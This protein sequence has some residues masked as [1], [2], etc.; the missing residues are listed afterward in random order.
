MSR[1]KRICALI[2]AGGQGQRAGGG[3]PKQYR[4]VGG[5]PVLRWAI[6]A[7]G[8]AVPG[9]LIT[10][11]ALP[12]HRAL[13]DSAVQGLSLAPPIAGGASRAESVRNGLVALAVDEPDIVLIHDAAR[14]FVTPATVERLIAA[15]ADGEVQGAAPGLRASDSLKRVGAD[16]SIEADIDRSRLWS[17]QTPQVFRYESIALAFRTHFSADATDDVAIARA[18][19]LKVQMVDGDPANV[20]LTYA[21]DFA[22]A[23]KRITAALGDVRT[24]AGLDVHAFGS[25]DH[26]YLCGIKV[27]HA[28]GLVGHS[29]ADVGLHALTDAILGAIGAGDI[30]VHFP[31]SDERWRGASSD[32]F[33]RHAQSLVERKGG[34]IAHCDVTLICEAPKI[35][36][37]RTAMVARI[38]EILSIDPSRV[39]VKATTTEGLGFA[40]RREGI[41]AMATATVRLPL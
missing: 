4:P 23:E 13:Y 35:G 18:A 8:E 33:L 11:V 2:V 14:P 39:S 6:Q 30:G 28:F 36:L 32:H 20:K 40:G 21:A 31:P 26:V 10:V 22:A 9:V 15:V 37:H 27:P 24:G 3:L 19:G 29:D 25:G 1:G 38:A 17:V 41:A 16:Q 5:V 7:I 12:E 34:I